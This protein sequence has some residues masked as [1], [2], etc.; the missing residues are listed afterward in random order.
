M[1][2][3]GVVDAEQL[4]M[5][6]KALNEHCIE[7][8]VQSEQERENIAYRV[9]ALFVAGATSAEALKAALADPAP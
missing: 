2:F 7:R 4:A 1:P 6:T 9:M 3:S 8:G 5:L